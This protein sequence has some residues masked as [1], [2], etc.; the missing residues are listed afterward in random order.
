MFTIETTS[1]SARRP[2]RRAFRTGVIAVA[3]GTMPALALTAV[4]TG[5]AQAA[6][7]KTTVQMSVT[8]GGFAPGQGGN[9][10]S[11]QSE[12]RLIS[13]DGRFVV[14]ESSGP[15]VAGQKELDR[16]IVRRDRKLGTT[17]L[18]SKSTAGVKGKSH[19]YDPSISAD[20][21][22]VA[23][24]SS[25]SNLVAGDTNGKTDIFVH[26]VRARTTKRASVT[27]AGHQTS[28]PGPG[29][30]IVGPPSISADGRYVGFTSSAQGL[31]ADDT[32]QENAYLHDRTLRTTEVVSRSIHGLVVDTLPSTV[33]SVSA[34]GRLV[35]FNSANSSVVA[36]D[37]NGDRDT[38]VR[39]RIAATTELIDSGEDG[40]FNHSMTPDGRF[41]AFESSSDNLVPNDTNSK[42][43][44]FVYDRQAQPGNGLSRVSVG[45][46]RTQA[47]GI[48]GDAAVS[49]DGRFVTFV[50]AA[51]NLVAGDTNAQDD[52]FRHDRTTGKTIRIS[53]AQ[54]G[55][56]NPLSSRK[57]AISGDGQ[58]VVFDSHGRTLTKVATKTWGQVFVRDLAGKWP[59]LHARI[60]ALPSRVNRGASYK[61]A[62]RDIRTGPA[63]AITW[64]PNGKSKGTIRQSAAVS[65]NKF[66]LR[67]PKRA[68]KYVVRVKYADNTVGT[69][70]INILKP[71]AKKLPKS[72][73]KGKKLKVRT[74][75]IAAGQK[76]A[77]YFKPMG[78]TKGKTT[79][80]KATVSKKGVAQVKT[81]SRRGTYRV[82]IGAQGKTIRKAVVRIR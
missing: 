29:T 59:A 39:D 3:A 27:S 44:V 24:R 71:A 17:T 75:G 66:T 40:S 56:Q 30:N 36:N 68:G 6:A 25:A 18:I 76:I 63:L 42:Y 72:I 58:H 13:K 1:A 70:T 54:N 10:G 21:H 33:V 32:N 62:T 20:G 19:S 74:V 57:P 9:G 79:K 64:S 4:T 53:V 28:T 43:D 23:F 14:F 60:G 15:V 50:S 65:G 51:T 49:N 2:L 61:V 47:N 31:A 78:N 45:D 11:T 48:S 41:V 26:D 46:G 67:S 35:A 69:R 81:V 8:T 82:I 12:R 34:D 37:T 22:V 80:R 73:K 52:V 38:F 7:A 16:Q 5:T 77:V 55:A